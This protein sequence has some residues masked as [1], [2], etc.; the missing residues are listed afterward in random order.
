MIKSSANRG[1]FAIYVDAI[2]VYAEELKNILKS[3]NNKG[4]QFWRNNVSLSDSFLKFRIRDLILKADRHGNHTVQN[5][6][7][8]IYTP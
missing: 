4:E 1:V 8:L 5:I 6:N 7:S 3:T 2:S